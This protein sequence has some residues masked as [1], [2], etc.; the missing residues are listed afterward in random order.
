ME[1]IPRQGADMRRILLA[2]ATAFLI[3]AALPA[4]AMATTVQVNTEADVGGA[5]CG[6]VPGDCSIRQAIDASSDDDTVAIPAGH[7]V[8][9]ASLKALYVDR[10]ITFQG[11]G[12]PV[13]DGGGKIGVFSIGDGG[14]VFGF[15]FPTAT[16][17]GV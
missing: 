15:S 5:G 17:D 2:V 6:G 14:Q 12:N 16:I 4:L 3:A 11:T 10:N 9:D 1:W 8:L 7:Y 13:I